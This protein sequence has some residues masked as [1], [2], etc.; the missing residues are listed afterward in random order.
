MG[1]CFAGMLLAKTSD[2]AGDE[3]GW[4]GQSKQRGTHDLG[5]R[6]QA[7]EQRRIRGRTVMSHIVLNFYTFFAFRYMT[8]MEQFKYCLA[9][10]D[11]GCEFET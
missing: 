2:F 9:W 10:D 5:V 6:E 3:M 11:M 7:E 1:F 8:C 4:D